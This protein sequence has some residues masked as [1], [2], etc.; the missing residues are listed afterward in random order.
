LIVNL[1]IAGIFCL[2]AGAVAE[3]IAFAQ[4]NSSLFSY[5]R[6]RN[7]WFGPGRDRFNSAIGFYASRAALALYVLGSVLILPIYFYS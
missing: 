2:I 7:L 4:S 1:V 3:F 6:E 5:I